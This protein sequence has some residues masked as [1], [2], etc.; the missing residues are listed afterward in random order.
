MTE[1][2]RKLLFDN[3]G[4]KF[5]NVTK[6]LGEGSTDHSMARINLKE[7]RDNLDVFTTALVSLMV[8]VSGIEG[9]LDGLKY[10]MG[11]LE[12]YLESP[13]QSGLTDQD[14]C[15]FIY[16]M[17]SSYEELIGMAEELDEELKR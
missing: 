13:A 6:F 5:T 8:D 14:A 1:S 17:L 7:I 3:P 9:T 15:I 11:R 16:Y 2:Y 10:P 12:S 4:Y